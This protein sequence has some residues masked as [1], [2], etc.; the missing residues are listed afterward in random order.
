[1]P[2]DNI[3]AS[4]NL[5]TNIMENGVLPFNVQSLSQLVKKHP[6]R[7]KAPDEILLD[8]PLP[9]VHTV[10]FLPADE[11][12]TRKVAF[13][14]VSDSSGMDTEAWCK[15]LGQNQF[16]TSNTDLQPFAE[17]INRL[18]TNLVETKCIEVLP[19]C[20]LITFDKNP[21]LKPNGVGEVLRCITG[22]VIVSIFKE[23]IKKR[24]ERQ[25]HCKFVHDRR[26]ELR[27]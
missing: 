7:K 26:V 10:S 22:K 24:Q 3:I 2:K 8:G 27:Q 25:D 4:M 17:V 16:K 21:E 12:M 1:M 15:I 23:D 6:D 20:L 11:K 13:K 18:C 19:F 9:N 5:V 14:G